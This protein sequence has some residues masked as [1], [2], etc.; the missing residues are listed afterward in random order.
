MLGLINFTDPGAINMH[1]PQSSL[2]RRASQFGLALLFASMAAHAS[3]SSY[4]TGIGERS[5]EPHVRLDVPF[6]PTPHDVVAKMLELADVGPSDFLID[7]GAGDGRIAVAAVRDRGA[8]GAFGVDLN[9]VR[10]EE[11]RANAQD[12]GVADRVT[13]N[14][15]D[16]FE[17]DFSQA[18]V[19]SMYLLP[20]VNLKLRPK[21]LDMP[22]GTRI[23]SH[24][25]DMGDWYADTHA[26]VDNLD[27]YLWI[28]P[29]DVSGAW[30]LTTADGDIALNVT[31]EFQNIQGEASF[32]GQPMA[33]VSGQ[34]RGHVVQ[35]DIDDGSS[36]RR[37]VGR[38]T[39]DVIEP[40]PE[41]GAQPDW[42]ARR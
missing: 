41:P 11:A 7:L 24:A 19:I 35:F 31:Q 2:F 38:V 30:T 23:V 13:F 16:L 34:L 6:V 10:V 32:D 4:S 28:V 29:E 33:S 25:F 40:M 14:V 27:V 36:T 1:V 20:N 15:E 12:A 5:Y 42:R 22:P 9:P 17:T 39:G 18:T 26:R 37:Y 3:A 21:I 8:R